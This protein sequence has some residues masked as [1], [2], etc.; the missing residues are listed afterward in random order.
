LDEATNS[1]RVDDEGKT[2]KKERHYE[3]MCAELLNDGAD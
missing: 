1:G 3:T 2:G